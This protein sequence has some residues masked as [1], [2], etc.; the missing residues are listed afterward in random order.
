MAQT[1]NLR[2]WQ[3][4]SGDAKDVEGTKMLNTEARETPETVTAENQNTEYVVSHPAF[5]QDGAT[6]RS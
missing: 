6:G 1:P 2:T 5:G 4:S 3:P